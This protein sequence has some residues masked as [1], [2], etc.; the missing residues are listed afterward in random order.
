MHS[1]PHPDDRTA[2]SALDQPETIP[3]GVNLS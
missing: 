2:S 1:N 3:L